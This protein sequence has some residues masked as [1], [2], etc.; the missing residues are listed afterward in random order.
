[1]VGNLY[2]TPLEQGGISIGLK[3]TLDVNLAPA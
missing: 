1:M 3:L 2:A